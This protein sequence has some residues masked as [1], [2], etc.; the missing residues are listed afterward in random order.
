MQDGTYFTKAPKHDPELVAQIER[1]ATKLEAPLAGA[2]LTALRA[3]S[4]RADLD[5]LVK[6]LESGDI[7]R[8]LAMLDLESMTQA[9]TPIKAQMTGTVAA[10]G[11]AVVASSPALRG[12]AIAFDV[13]N[14]GTVGWLQ[15]YSLDL[16]RQINE[17]SRDGIR[18]ALVQAAA[19]GL[20]PRD[21]AGTIRNVVGL[22][23][24][25][26]RAVLNYRR[27]LET[28]HERRTGGGFN[29]G[30]KPDR[31]NGAQVFRPGEDGQPKDGITEGRLR[32]YRY[33]RTLQSAVRSKKPIPAAQIDK[34]VAA[35]HR[36]YLV[37]RAQ[38]IARTESLRAANIAVLEAWRQAITAGKVDE[39]AVRKQWIV[40]R[41]ERLC[42]ICAPIPG[43][44]PIRGVAFGQPFAT[45][46]GPVSAPPVHPSCRCVIFVRAYERFELQ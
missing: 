19:R 38:T 27:K 6:A 16:I 12:A 18:E 13:L 36:K 17:S 32:D 21:T 22:T 14:P 10:A 40:A 9:L 44:N 8:V 29:L 33:D 7:G 5:A 15:T 45:T 35:Y 42:K 4:D 41:D 34:M 24:S 30:A 26:A 11:A 31:V 25:Q 3:Q 43:L 37:H 2:I 1:Q 28:F 39:D 20:G 46:R 23:E